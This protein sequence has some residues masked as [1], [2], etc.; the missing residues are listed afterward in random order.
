MVLPGIAGT[1][2]F[3]TTE[4]PF[5]QD[6]SVQKSQTP[7]WREI[8]W[9]LDWL[10]LHVSPVYWGCGIPRGQGEPVIVVPG[11]L[12]DDSYMAELYLWLARI[13]Y[14]PFY[15]RIGENSDCPDHLARVLADT[16]RNVLAETGQRPRLIGHS[17]GGMLS[18][19]VALE[20]PEL[21]AGVI[22]LGSPFRDTVRAHPA[23]LAAAD[24]LR[25]GRRAGVPTGPHIRPSCFSGHCLCTFNRQ[26][27]APDAYHVPHFAVFS[28][29]DGVCEW[30]SCIEDDPE[31][32]DEVTSTHL[33]MAFHP[34]VYGIVARRLAQMRETETTAASEAHEKAG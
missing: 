22:S 1:T 5:E 14:Q 16:C 7:L 13:G 30:R 2:A 28:K 8:Y 26:V 25:R 24:A 20:H 18:R 11:F 21:T 10:S 17:L 32:N 27:L 9:G 4:N 12:T 31:L 15:S 19:T 29:V 33:G 34:G 23:V 6:P 3:A